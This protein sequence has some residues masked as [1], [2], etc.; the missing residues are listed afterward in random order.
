MLVSCF[1]YLGY[2]NARFGRIEAHEATTAYGR[3]K[4][5]RAKEIA[6]AA[7]FRVLHALI[8]S[9]WLKREGATEAEVLELCDE[10]TK[11]TQIEMSLE[12]IYNWVV[13][14]PSKANVERPVACRYYGVFSDGR[15][16][17]R[18]L[19]CRRSDTPEFIKEVQW[20]MLAI[21]SRA[22]TLEDRVRLVEEAEFVLQSRIREIE[23]GEVDPK[24][25]LLG[26]QPTL[27]DDCR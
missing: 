14:L 20:E 24:K 2:K 1:G 26:V 19:A 22:K 10:I 15:L 4:L 12:G 7:G 16:K 3:E 11:A 27:L 13:F 18:G 23:R 21:V 8:D 17:L 25:H 9:L 6:E 5:L